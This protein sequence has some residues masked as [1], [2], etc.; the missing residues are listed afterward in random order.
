MLVRELFNYGNNHTGKYNIGYSQWNQRT[1]AQVHQLI[2][3][4]TRNGPAHPHKEEDEREQC[5]RS[6]WHAAK[7]EEGHQGL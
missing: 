1:P 4:E 3:T 5:S 7:G 2:V 6:K